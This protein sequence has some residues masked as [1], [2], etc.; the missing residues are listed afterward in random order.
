MVSAEVH[1]K[2]LV[3]EEA[4]R[5]VVLENTD[6]FAFGSTC[7]HKQEIEVKQSGGRISEKGMC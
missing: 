2:L 1:G 5:R 4:R 7:S 6:I 3:K